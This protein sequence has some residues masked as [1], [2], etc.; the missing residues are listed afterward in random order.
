MSI[1]EA[2]ADLRQLASPGGCDGDPDSV[3]ERVVAIL[4][5]VEALEM[6]YHREKRTSIYW[7]ERAQELE[8]APSDA[9]RLQAEAEQRITLAGAE[10]ILRTDPTMGRDE[11]EVR[12]GTQRYRFKLADD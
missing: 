10:V 3:R 11:I 6:L 4:K 2:I 12:Q 1:D 8:T 5:G 7:F 9:R